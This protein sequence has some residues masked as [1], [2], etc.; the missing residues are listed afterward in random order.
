MQ[1]KRFNGY[2]T[3]ED[4]EDMAGLHGIELAS[5]KS[6]AG[7][8][9]DQMVMLLSDGDYYDSVILIK[10]HHILLAPG[11]LLSCIP[12]LLSASGNAYR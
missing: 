12:L 3:L 6:P 7:I 2:P 9:R 10:P 5:L 4:I 11:Y 1:G 8:V